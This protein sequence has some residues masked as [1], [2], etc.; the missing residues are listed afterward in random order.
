MS[1]LHA[2]NFGDGDNFAGAVR[3]ARDLNHGVNGGRDLVAHRALGNIQICHRNHVLDTGERVAL[4]VGVDRG[5]RAVVTGVHGLQ[6]VEGLFAAH[7]AQHDAVGT[8]TQ[9]VDHQLPL[10]DRALAFNVRRA[11]FQP[12][13]VFLLHL[14]FGG[15]FDGDDAFV[16]RNIAGQ[17]VQNGRFAGAGSTRDQQV[18]PAFHHGRQQLQ[19]GFGEGSCSRSSDGR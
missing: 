12:H 3:E 5:Q 4:R 18:Q 14:Q 2:G 16:I 1:A 7:L 9:A 17:N 11:G 8:H 15:V 13:H 10:P 19:H 6:H